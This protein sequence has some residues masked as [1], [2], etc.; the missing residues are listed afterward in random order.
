MSG[1][2]CPRCGER[3]S[4]SGCAACALLA[5]EGGRIRLT[6][7]LAAQ[8]NFGALYF[9]LWW[10][11]WNAN[12]RLRWIGLG[13]MLTAPVTFGVPTLAYNLYLFVRGNRIA[14][15]DRGFASIEHFREVQRRWTAW[16]F[17]LAA[18][19]FVL[20]VLMGARPTP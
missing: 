9:G 14:A 15:R 16:G 2:R 20:G 4:V 7:A 12:V 10:A 13:C 5:P 18:A 19:S 1:G 17:A 6:A 3:T 11:L 8:P